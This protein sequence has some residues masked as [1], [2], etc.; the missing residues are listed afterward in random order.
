MIR[1]RMALLLI[2]G[3][4]SLAGSSA[5]AKHP[6]P[7]DN[8]DR[9]IVV[10]LAPEGVFIDY[11]VE[12]DSF[13]M[14]RDLDGVDLERRPDEDIHE[15]Y[16]RYFSSALMGNL[17]VTLNGREIELEVVR[18]S[19]RVLDHVRCDYRFRG[20]WQLDPN[21]PYRFAFRDA[22]YEGDLTSQIHLALDSSPELTVS[23]VVAPDDALLT[24][25]VERLTLDER[26][27]LRRLRATLQAIPT[28]RAGLVRPTLPPDPQPL[29]PPPQ[30][31]TRML[32]VEDKPPTA[33]PIGFLK[34]NG[35]DEV[36]A[37]RSGWLEVLFDTRYG[38]GVLLLIFA[39]FGAAH[40][41]TP[42]HGK[43]L[44]AAYLVG[45]R[46]T[47]GH[48]LV[49]GIVTTLTH[50]GIIMIVALVLPWF[51]P[52]TPPAAV[53]AILGLVGGLLIAGVGVWL[54]MQRLAGRADHLHLPGGHSHSHGAEE[55]A[56]RPGWWGVILMG[57]SGGLVPCWDAI[58]I[59]AVC[60]TAQR[61]ELAWP[62]VLAFSAGL[63]SVLVALGFVVV[64]GKNLA[65]GFLDSPR[66]QWLTRAL[67]IVSAILIVVLG[68][69][70]CWESVHLVA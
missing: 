55:M 7:K 17:A 3:L 62:L 1:L 4:L 22:N 54:F 27:Q 33:A 15:A 45:E 39:S 63:A 35:P 50:T 40:A 37:T 64:V 36:P 12:L 66:G 5:W 28:R 10:L 43:T 57:V 30:G 70:L 51:F 14:Y 31:R 46:G 6:V 69:W 18:R 20:R 34:P 53:Q 38:L 65:G 61:P 19:F 2:G 8:H 16:L 23:E 67:P 11:R 25:A 52:N 29:R 60:V 42:G 13:R 26:E 58:L 68:L 59:P 41:L 56:I 47:L 21:E 32:A 9:T 49:L 44:V 48:A 24:K